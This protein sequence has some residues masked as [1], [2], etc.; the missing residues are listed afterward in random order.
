MVEKLYERVGSVG[1]NRNA[2]SQSRLM[3]AA[4]PPLARQ[5]IDIIKS[6]R[7]PRERS[8]ILDP[9]EEFR[10]VVGLD[11]EQGERSPAEWLR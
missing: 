9:L 5:T 7:R 2:L 6:G 10:S 11:R 4:L 1:D 3:R 8:E